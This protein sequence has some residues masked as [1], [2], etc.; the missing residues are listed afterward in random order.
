MIVPIVPTAGVAFTVI[1][2]QLGKLVPQALP[3]VTQTVP[4]AL[5]YVTVMPV[6]PWPAVIVAVAGTVQVYTS[7]LGTLEIE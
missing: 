1:T 6:V 5:P 3:A 4:E 2:W 7:V